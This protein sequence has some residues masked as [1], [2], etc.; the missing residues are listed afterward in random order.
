MNS[1]TIKHQCKTAIQYIQNT[2]NAK[3]LILS[4]NENQ[5]KT[6][7]LAL[8]VSKDNIS[9]CDT[10]NFDFFTKESFANSSFDLIIGNPPNTR[11]EKIREIKKRFVNFHSFYNTADLNVYYFEKGFT[12]LRKNALLSFFTNSKYET[13][14]Y[15]Q[16]FRKFIIEHSNIVEYISYKNS[17]SLMC[18]SKEDNK[19]NTFNYTNIQKKSYRYRQ[20]DLNIKRFKFLTPKELEIKEKIESLM[21]EKNDTATYIDF[22]QNSKVVVFYKNLMM[23][24]TTKQ[25]PLP[26]I[27]QEIQKIF[28]ILVDYI[29]FAKEQNMSLEAS[30]F[31]SVIDS[32][33]YDLY[34]E[35][36]MKRGDCFISDEVNK[37]IIEF[38]DSIDRIKEMYKIL[39]TNKT[40]G[41]G[42]IYSRIIPVVEIINGASK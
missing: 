11:Q 22:I 8:G 10:S 16:N 32:M 4:N 3:V 31:E 19:D 38:N 24:D 28:E 1:N 6:I 37:V 13:A 27:S 34:F 41:R 5:Y 26:Q 30:L 20:K 40:I 25:I 12:F 18:L 36:E 14:K 9:Y 35:E 42:L 23:Y 2:N 21:S 7:L 15:A 33:V 17:Y 39:N 29:L